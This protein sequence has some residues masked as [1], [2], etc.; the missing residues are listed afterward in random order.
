MFEIL[1][2]RGGLSLDRLRA[3]CLVAEAGGIARAV[4]PDPTRQSLVSRQLKELEEFFELELTR[5]EGKGLALT[6][7]GR[8]LAA[9]AREH[10]AALSDFAETSQDAVARFHLAA[11]DSLLHW[12]I[13][14]RLARL[15]KALPRVALSVYNDD[16]ADIAAQLRDLTLDFGVLRDGGGTL[17]SEPLGHLDH[18][19]Y[20][21]RALMP[22]G[23]RPHV[24]SLLARL[25]LAVPVGD[26]RFLR[27]LDPL[28]DG[29]ALFECVTFPQAA[30]AVA[31]GGHAAVLP[32]LARTELPRSTTLEVRSDLF[33]ELRADICLSWNPRLLRLRAH[34][35]AVRGEL[36]AALRW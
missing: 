1:F 12:R 6:P 26:D 20:V 8:R 13:I 31:S 35:D 11:G 24:R 10:L 19:L 16:P 34:A 3:L 21:P 25:P 14:P 33:D 7:A 5:R 28:V 15:R 18:A 9:L 23:R 29:A 22:A 32:E 17:G 27:W 30:R 2:S 4:G 36:L